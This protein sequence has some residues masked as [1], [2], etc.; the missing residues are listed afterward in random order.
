V[1]YI[2]FGPHGPRAERVKDGW[3]ILGGLATCMAVSFTLFWILRQ[4]RNA[5]HHADADVLVTPPPPRTMTQ[6]WQ[7]ATNERLKTLGI[8]PISG[9]GSPDYKAHPLDDDT[10]KQGRGVIY[11]DFVNKKSRYV[12]P[13]ES[14]EE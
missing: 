14:D 9:P 2:N 12:P 7:E 3:Q 11:G 1:Y 5:I 4:F 10:D 8:E 13:P 6:E